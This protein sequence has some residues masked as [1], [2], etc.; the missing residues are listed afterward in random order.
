MNQMNTTGIEQQNQFEMAGPEPKKNGRTKAPFFLGLALGLMAGCAVMYFA[1]LQ[2]GPGSGLLS[3]DG[4]SAMNMETAY[5]IQGLEEAIDMYYYKADEVTRSQKEEGIY[6]GLIRS[7]GDPYSVYYTEEE[8]RELDS[9]LSGTYYGIGAYLSMDTQSNLPKISGVIEGTPAEEAGLMTNDIIYKIDGESTQGLDL[10]EVVK[11]VRGKEG[12]TVDLTLLRD[13]EIDPIEARIRRAKV[14]SPTVSSEVLEDTDGI[15]YIQITEF[16]D[17]TSGQ[18]STHLKKL[19]DENIR[20]LIIDLRD[21][22]GGSVDAATAVAGELLPEGLVFYMEERNGKRTDYRCDGKHEIRIPLAVLVNENSASAAEIL[23]GAVQDSGKG[24]IIGTR[25]YGKGVVQSVFSL[26]DG[27][28]LKLTVADYYTRNGNNINGIGIT[29]DMEVELDTEAYVDK[30]E[31][32]QL[33]KAIE[34]IGK[35]AD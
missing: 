29:P 6:K 30:G 27:S 15:G 4:K 20:G 33:E 31:D 24:L 17:V 13:G 12:T 22:P 11:R 9:S 8:A 21:N 23:S 34:E 32:N 16:D 2:F 1:L 7:L 3:G 5:K 10:D 35:M 28:G 14:D 26:N 18:F 25:T 19:Y